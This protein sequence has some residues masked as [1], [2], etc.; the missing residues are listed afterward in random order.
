MI[1]IKTLAAAAFATALLAVPATG[2]A[3]GYYYHDNDALG[4][5]DLH[6]KKCFYFPDRDKFDKV[7]FGFILDSRKD[8]NLICIFPYVPHFFRNDY[9]FKCVI[10]KDRYVFKKTH[11]S[12]FIVDKWKRKAFMKCDFKKYQEYPDYED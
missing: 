7:L 12:V 1:G 10:A 5:F 3:Q 4:V 11:D 9:D 8:F 6:K 2:R